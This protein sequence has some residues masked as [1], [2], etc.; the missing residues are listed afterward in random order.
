[1]V[2]KSKK[3]AVVDIETTGGSAYLGKI[4]DI[5]ILI[6]DGNTIIERFE[7]LVNPEQY[8]PYKIQQLTGISNEMVADAPIFE[9]LAP[10]IFELLSDKIF[11]AHNVNFDYSFIVNALELAG[12]QLNVEKLCTVRTS[13][14]MIPGYPSYS[15]GNIC[16]QLH[17]PIYNRHR[18]SGDADATLELLRILLEKEAKEVNY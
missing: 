1:M 10:R 11:V 6:F 15:L 16:A 17:I 18:A 12:F 7:S 9:T 3:Y 13:R 14:K 8:I 5:A 4:T 2:M